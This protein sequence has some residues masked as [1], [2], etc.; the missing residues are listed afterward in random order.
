MA[1]HHQTIG[2]DHFRTRRASKLQALFEVYLASE[3]TLLS[4][5]L[6]LLDIWVLRI[7]RLL[8]KC[9]GDLLGEHGPQ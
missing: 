3:R 2:D 6:F 5:G 8:H 1:P 7:D 4:L 9:P